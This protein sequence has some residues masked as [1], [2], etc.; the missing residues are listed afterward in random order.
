[1]VVIG[2][3]LD[4]VAEG[5]G[6]ND[7]GSGT[8]TIL[9]IAI[10]LRKLGIATQ[11]RLRFAFF[12]AEEWGLLGS[13]H[14]VGQLTP[15]ELDKI[16][17]NLN[18]DMLGSPNPVSFVYDGDGSDTGPVGPEGSGEIEAVFLDYF[19]GANLPTRPTAFDGRSDY[20]P[21]IAKGI[22]AG[23]LF[24]GAEGLKTEDEAA[25]F[26]GTA[27][28]AYD[29]CYHKACDD[30][31]NVSEPELDKLSDAAAH[32][33]LHFGTELPVPVVTAF[34]SGAGRGASAVPLESLPFR[35]EGQYQN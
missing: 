6:I 2:A 23:G 7:N 3:H 19:Q 14:Y 1:M 34:R 30:L 32:A 9:E 18:F 10:Q 31:A 29:K 11:N 22:P 27:G 5:P 8:G 16:V 15:E 21:F 12:G 28:E 24:T 4:S 17:L 33:V 20:G 25:A 13:A 35:G 26:G